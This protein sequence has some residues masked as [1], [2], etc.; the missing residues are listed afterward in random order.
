MSAQSG[1]KKTGLIRFSPFE[2]LRDIKAISSVSSA[3]PVALVEGAQTIFLNMEAILRDIWGVSDA[4]IQ[5]SAASSIEETLKTFFAKECAIMSLQQLKASELGASVKATKLGNAWRPPRYGR[6]LVVERRRSR[7]LSEIGELLGVGF[8]KAPE[9][10]ILIDIKGC[11]VAPGVTPKPLAHH[12]GLFSLSEAIEEIA[13]QTIVDEALSRVLPNV[14]TLPVYAVVLFP[15][16]GDREDEGEHFATLLFRRAH[17]RPAGNN[18]IPRFLSHEYFFK[19]EVEFAL[20]QCGVTSAGGTRLQIQREKDGFSATMGARV[21]DTSDKEG[22]QRFLK[23]MNI[24]A[25]FVADVVNVQCTKDV[26]T[27]PVSGELLDFGHYE[28]RPNFITP[29]MATAWDF[30]FHCGGILHPNAVQWVNSKPEM[31]FDGEIFMRN[32]SSDPFYYTCPRRGRRIGPLS[33]FKSTVISLAAEMYT[34]DVS[35][36]DFGGKVAALVERVVSHQHEVPAPPPV[37]DR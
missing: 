30:D 18:E 13:T 2:P 28:V 22:V 20:R 7:R 12:T 26:S 10:Q 4:D 6:A 36:F 23:T 21:I 37:F 5:E 8:E 14:Y 33:L 3:E 32:E 29:I 9:H 34:T 31:A 11:G 17:A 1:G 15:F 16:T 25:P 27:M 35:E 19:L 24:Q